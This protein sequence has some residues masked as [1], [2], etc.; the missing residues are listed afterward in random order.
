MTTLFNP[1][2]PHYRP[3]TPAPYNLN[4]RIRISFE[5]SLHLQALDLFNAAL[6]TGVSTPSDPP[7]PASM[8]PP[9][10][11]RFV[12]TLMV[13]PFYTT[14][15]R[16]DIPTSNVSVRS[17]LLLRRVIKLI[18]VNGGDLKAAW[19]FAPDL[20]SGRRRRQKVKELS[21]SL[22]DSLS[23]E[24]ANEECLFTVA[25]DMWSVVGWAFVC[26]V[27]HPKRWV[28]WKPFLECVITA[29]EDDFEQ[30]SVE[31]LERKTGY[32][33]DTQP[34]ESL[35]VKM[36]HDT[37]GNVGYRRVLRAIFANGSEKSRNEFTQIWPD[38]LLRRRPKMKGR[39]GFEGL[40]GKDES[41]GEDESS[42]DDEISGDDANGVV[43]NSTGDDNH[44]GEDV[45]MEDADSVS[46][47]N[48]DEWGGI[49]AL[50]F[51]HRLLKLL[52]AVSHSGNFIPPEDLCHEFKDSI[53]GFPIMSFK[54][55]T[56]GFL[57]SGL[58]AY[59]SNLNLIILET[60]I[61]PRAPTGPNSALLTPEIFITRFLPYPAKTSSPIENAKVALLLEALMR[62]LVE[63]T[64]MNWSQALEIATL[65]GTKARQKQVNRT[66]AHAKIKDLDIIITQWKAA[67]ERLR[68]VVRILK[69]KSDTVGR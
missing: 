35:I 53:L 17:Y 9:A 38:E 8:L 24:L 43:N 3:V 31:T 28:W 37:Y 26:A 29:F 68:C 6:F 25:N 48:V 64:D 47:S 58:A 62:L 59:Q 32:S 50:L 41:S 21:P 54:L 66:G 42:N 13:H 14:Q 45:E 4:E 57:D 60:I 49:D 61:S 18:G 63:N 36:L 7:K 51:R 22:E 20:R 1:N 44:D 39:R 15:T 34:A 56:S 12:T 55:F 16:K 23:G 67:E 46:S 27:S 40:M 33:D 2:P 5:E 69:A 30:R 19:Y 52:S 11:L 65:N 10:F